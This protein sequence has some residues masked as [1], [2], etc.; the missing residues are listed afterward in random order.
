MI[1]YVAGEQ[2]KTEGVIKLNTNECPYPPG[3]GVKAALR[4]FDYENLRLY[5]DMDAGALVDALA[6]YYGVRPGQVFVGVGSDD[7][8]ALSFMA[9]FHGEKPI[10][11]PDIHI[12]FTMCG[13]K[14]FGF[15]GKPVL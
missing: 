2:P 8:L 14:F 7:V 15:P 5:P 1:P 13:R 9:F 3:M 12:P 11:F 6:T 4:E 10:L